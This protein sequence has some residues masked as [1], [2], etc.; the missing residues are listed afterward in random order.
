MVYSDDPNGYITMPSVGDLQNQLPDVLQK[1]GYFLTPQYDAMSPSRLKE[2]GWYIHP[3][4]GQ[5]IETDF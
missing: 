1:N 4:T 3:K 5:R 2:K